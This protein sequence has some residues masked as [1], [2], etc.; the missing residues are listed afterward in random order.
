M[1]DELDGEL[2]L[3][4]IDRIT[5]LNDKLTNYTL[6][7][8][9]LLTGFT[10]DLFKLEARFKELEQDYLIADR[11]TDENI[12]L[13]QE[14]R[15][16]IQ[17]FKDIPDEGVTEVNKSLA[18]KLYNV[19]CDTEAV[20]K[21]TTVGKNT[22]G[23]YKAVGEAD[24]LNMIKP[25]FK[26]HKLII[27]PVDGT[28]TEH[29][30]K[31]IAYAKEGTR[32]VTQLKVY[33]DIIDAETGESTRIVGFGNGADSQDKGSGKAFTYSLKT[34]LQKTFL[35][36]SGEDTDNTHS[37]EITKS[38]QGEQPRKVTA[39]ELIEMAAKKGYTSEK[40]CKKYGVS[41]VKYIKADKKIEAYDNFAKLPDKKG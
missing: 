27:M 26:K 8:E 23:E 39:N 3:K 12:A 24:V 2:K 30:D 1:I 22:K 16:I 21:G 31:T 7:L 15:D 18:I 41:E 29:V 4:Y 38:T 11:K 10:G 5:T 34:A 17:G 37:D 32:S 9:T 25:L 13:E 40:L 33:F 35:M 19:M 14:K 6:T 36:F 20:E 28:I